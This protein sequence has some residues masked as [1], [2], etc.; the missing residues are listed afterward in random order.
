MP[1][2]TPPF[3]HPHVV[4]REEF[5]DWALLYNPDTAAVVGTNPTGVAMWKQIDG[6]KLPQDIVES[7]LEEFDC[8]PEKLT[9]DLDK[10]LD[11]LESRGFIG[12]ELDSG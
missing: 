3:A 11:Q 10:F 4:L 7:L 9:E 6:E 5:D 8:T 12:F 1:F 2:T